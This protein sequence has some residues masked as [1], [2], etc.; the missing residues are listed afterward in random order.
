MSGREGINHE[1]SGCRELTDKKQN[2][3]ET[4]RAFYAHLFKKRKRV[5]KRRT[6]PSYHTASY[7]NTILTCRLHELY[8]SE[9]P[10]L[11]RDLVAH[12]DDIVEVSPLSEMRLEHLFGGLPRQAAKE[13]L[14]LDIRF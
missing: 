11:A 5:K 9:A 6:T 13:D 14:P 8:E 7:R 2:S 12:Q 10:G 3:R 1:K 4:R